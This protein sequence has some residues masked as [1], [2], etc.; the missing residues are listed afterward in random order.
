V[1]SI[2]KL[3]DNYKKFDGLQ[4]PKDWLVD[5]LDT[6]KLMGGTKA[7]TIQSIQVHL[8]GAARLWMKNLPEGSTD[9]WETFEELFMKNFRS[10][11]KKPTSIEQLRMCKQK[12]DETIRA[13]IQR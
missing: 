2:F 7:T 3:P 4:D 11:Y 8:S 10:T 12:P 6:V 9:S 1:S 13:Y 5:Y